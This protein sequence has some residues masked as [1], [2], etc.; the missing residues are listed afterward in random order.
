[1]MSS[2]RFLTSILLLTLLLVSLSFNRFNARAHAQEQTPPS[3]T[4][5]PPPSPTPA[6]TGQPAPDDEVLRV[7]TNLVDVIFNAL[8]QNHRFV[9]TL[10]QS[11]IQIY[12]DNAPQNVSTFER[13]TDLPLSLALLLDT[14]ESQREVLKDEKTTA[15]EFLSA[16]IQP[17]K[18]RVA[19][20]SFTGQ[21]TLEQDLTDDLTN[22]RE[23]INR[24]KF[25]LSPDTIARQEA[26]LPPLSPE[27]DPSGY[28][29]VWDAVW[30]T[31][32][33]VLAHTPPRARR[34]IILLSDG[35]DTSSRIK[36]QE[37]ID[38]AFKNNVV[39]YSIGIRDENFPHGKLDAGA[40]RKVSERTGGRAFFPHDEAELRAAFAEIQ[41]E[42]RS[43]YL[44]AYS[45][46]NKARD[47]S[48]RRLRIEIVNPTL[49]KQ[50][51]LLTYRQGY[52]ARDA[53]VAPLEPK[54]QPTR[55]LARPGR[56]PKS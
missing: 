52:F 45:P 49:R 5:T 16:I 10:K 14:S 27:Q 32:D 9:T 42:L 35:D 28:T 26:G 48:F 29:S 30:V 33:E 17:Q 7:E 36:K 51:L 56:P 55:R 31:V 50:K 3:T 41:Q 2:K 43:Q 19:V 34:A 44:I 47:G 8:D 25:E 37:A 54:Q 40:L 21:A 23:A 46:A 4:Q 11:D 1:M 38:L 53:G 20:V 15:L 39:I 13:E 6:Q 24:V 22:A 18:D 12:E